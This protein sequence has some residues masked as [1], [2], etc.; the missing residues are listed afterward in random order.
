MILCVSGRG[1]TI[2]NKFRMSLGLPVSAMVNCADNI[3]LS[4]FTLYLLR[5]LRV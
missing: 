1:G 3:E 5:G 4:T 2:D